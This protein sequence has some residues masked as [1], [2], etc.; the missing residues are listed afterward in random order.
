[1]LGADVTLDILCSHGVKFGSTS[2]GSQD[3]GCL[4]LF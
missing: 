2:L 3:G 4:F 1:M